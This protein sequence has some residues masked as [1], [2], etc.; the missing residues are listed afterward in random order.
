MSGSGWDEAIN[1]ASVK[2]HIN[3]L[4]SD[5]NKDEVYA[6]ADATLN[7]AFKIGRVVNSVSRPHNSNLHESFSFIKQNTEASGTRKH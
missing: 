3:K 6:S 1:D 5:I 4:G 7:S 2:V